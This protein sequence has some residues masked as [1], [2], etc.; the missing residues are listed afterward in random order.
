MRV[1]MDSSIAT[2]VRFK[3]LAQDL[4]VSRNEVTGALFY[5]WLS[6][7]ER[8]KQTLSK[9]L[10]DASAD[11][12]GFADALV[13]A[14]LADDKGD[15]IVIHGVKDRIAFLKKQKAYLKIL[16]TIML[17]LIFLPSIS[18]HKK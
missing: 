16:F 5:L 2:D 9:R 17:L 15:S 14:E 10:A 4:G 12:K 7:Y 1:N 8:R 13:D 3:V 6:C 11:I 18:L